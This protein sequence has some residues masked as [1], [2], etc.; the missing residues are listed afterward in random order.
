MSV[1][2]NEEVRIMFYNIIPD[3]RNCVKDIIRVYGNKYEQLEEEHSKTS[4]KLSLRKSGV[5]VELEFLTDKSNNSYVRLC[6]GS[7]ISTNVDFIIVHTHNDYFNVQPYKYGTYFWQTS[8]LDKFVEI[9]RKH[10]KQYKYEN[11]TNAEKNTQKTEQLTINNSSNLDGNLMEVKEI[12]N[13]EAITK[14]TPDELSLFFGKVFCQ[15]KIY[16]EFLSS[17]YYDDKL[18]TEGMLPEQIVKAFAKE[19]VKFLKQK[20]KSD[21]VRVPTIKY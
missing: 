16:G 17:N 13:Y 14:M 15:G 20:N 9:V 7:N 6:V 19:Y 8:D 12:T 1:N 10:Y 5:Y 18:I 11:V 21:T 3:L 4:A 2:K